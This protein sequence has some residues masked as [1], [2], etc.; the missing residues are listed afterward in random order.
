MFNFYKLPEGKLEK[1]ITAQDPGW[2]VRDALIRPNKN[3]ILLQQQRDRVLLT[4]LSRYTEID[5]SHPDQRR[6]ISQ[7]AGSDAINVVQGISSFFEV[8]ADGN[9]LIGLQPSGSK[10]STG[11]DLTQVVAWNIDTKEKVV[12]CKKEN[13]NCFDVRVYN[14]L[15]MTTVSREEAIAKSIPY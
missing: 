4:S 11:A 12:I 6:I 8:T 3:T 10:T 1:S 5:F 14:P 9:W 15:K 7:E 2:I 13:I